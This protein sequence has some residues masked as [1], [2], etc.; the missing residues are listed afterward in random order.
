MIFFWWQSIDWNSPK[1]L[2]LRSGNCAGWLTSQIGRCLPFWDAKNLTLSDNRWGEVLSC[3]QR[4][5]LQCHPAGHFLS[6]AGKTFSISIWHTC[7][8]F[9]NTWCHYIVPFG[10]FLLL[11]AAGCSSANAQIPILPSNILLIDEMM[12]GQAI[13]D[14]NITLVMCFLCCTLPYWCSLADNR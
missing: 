14:R 13:A 7:S 2:T 9:A 5:A 4:M 8:L 3:W 11:Q 1:L 10:R 6:I 12:Q